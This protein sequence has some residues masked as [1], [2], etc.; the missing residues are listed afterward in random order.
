VESTYTTC[1][2]ADVANRLGPASENGSSLNI[3]KP[4]GSA[5]MNPP[6]GPDIAHK[7]TEF[8]M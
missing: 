4:K 8:T 3:L 6:S 5:P 7:H 2:W 1:G